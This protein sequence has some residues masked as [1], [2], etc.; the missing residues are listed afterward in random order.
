MAKQ[1]FLPREPQVLAGEHS[2]W[3]TTFPLLT[4]RTEQFFVSFLAQNLATEVDD[5][6]LWNMAAVPTISLVAE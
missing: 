6:I 2:L 1:I 5:R 4:A 3:N